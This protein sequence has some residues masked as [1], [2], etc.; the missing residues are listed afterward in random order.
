[1]G[2]SASQ[3]RLLT[4]TARLSDLEYQA[5][6]VEN[7]RIRL[8]QRTE[9]AATEYSNALEKKSLSVLSGVDSTSGT[10]QYVQATAYN[11]TNYAAVS[12]LDKQRFIKDSNGKVVVTD[13]ESSAYDK[14]NG[15]LSTFLSNM[16]IVTDP[17]KTGYDSAK[18]TYYTNVFNQIKSNGYNSPGNTNMYSTDWL[19]SQLSAGNVHLEEWNATG[20]QDGKGDFEAISWQSGDVSI[21]TDSDDEA[22][23]KAEADYTAKT[24]EIQSKDK[25]LELNLKQIDTEHSA[26]QTE[27]DSVKKV[28]DKN[29][30]RSF[31]TFNA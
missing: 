10:Y 9:E 27:F 14:S 15:T 3:A 19:Y 7:A 28:I 13:G 31:K 24:A 29:I 22:A 30:E 20:G 12:S 21:K 11:L 16:G 17:S 25:K 4:I 1:M 2:M 8:S 26:L 5:Q 23:T 6:T 18:V